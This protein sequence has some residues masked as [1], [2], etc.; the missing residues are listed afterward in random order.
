MFVGAVG[1]CVAL[2]AGM[3]LLVVSAPRGVVADVDAAP[4]SPPT[5]FGSAA[6]RPQPPRTP[7]RTFAS[8]AG[9]EDG[10]LSF[11]ELLAAAESGRVKAAQIEQASGGVELDFKDESSA[12]ATAP[13]GYD[14]LA[15]LLS[16]NGAAVE[17]AAIE[18]PNEPSFLGSVLRAFFII[19]LIVIV[20]FAVHLFNR[21]RQARN[22]GPLAGV[23]AIRRGTRV[24]DDAPK[25]LF[26]DIAGCDEAVEETKEFLD[27]LRK[28]ERF[29]NMGARVPGGLILEGPPGTGKTSLAKALA[30]E[31]EMP[32][33]AAS[34]SEFVEMYVGVGARRV[35]ELFDNARREEN[36]AVI[37]IDEIDAIGKKRGGPGNIGGNDEREQTLN[38]LLKQLD[39]FDPREG[40]I[41]VAATNR[42]DVL[43][44]ALLR[45]G[46]FARKVYVGLPDREGRKQILAVHS[47][48]KPI[49]PAVD[50]DYLAEI[51]AGSSGADL[52]E[53][54]NEAAIMAV[55]GDRDAISQKDLTEGHLRVLAGPERR[56]NPATPE[57]RKLIAYHESGHVLCAELCPTHE[58][59]QRAT[60]V[61]R[62]K[63][64]GLAVWGQVDRA[65]HSA[66]YLHEQLVCILGGRAAEQVI[67]GSV[68]S[69]AANDLQKANGLARHVVQELGLSERAGQVTVSGA[70]GAH[71]E[72]TR[73]VIDSEVER[74][75]R[76]AYADAV[77]LLEGHRVEL[78]SLAAALLERGDIDR[79]EILDAVGALGRPAAPSRATLGPGVDSPKPAAEP[80]R[81]APHPRRRR[82]AAL[83]RDLRRAIAA[84][85][86]R[87]ES[88]RGVIG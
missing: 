25:M 41:V 67:A 42:V 62:G 73:S 79:L 38:E 57:E 70:D 10:V 50:L 45:P 5:A 82:A 1:F 47:R 14:R 39:G 44:E 61:P 7:A 49:D 15:E 11:D 71:A 4:G 37:F 19:S 40:I 35:R 87:R 29:K 32:F 18:G 9:A 46:R 2:L 56:T 34:G 12:R 24:D 88:S 84:R 21:R 65:L 60:I 58:K 72:T 23:A 81:P 86:S 63:A 85:R 17:L 33:F 16:K 22:G 59:A 43:D 3:V 6:A 75:I 83:G 80:V 13:L 51:T 30:G 68:T 53:M 55:R 27:F 20:L 31:A 76:E 64:A 52:A 8:Q 36:G 54:I 78:D 66:Q 74:L 77:R 26:S 69:G 28:P 48:G